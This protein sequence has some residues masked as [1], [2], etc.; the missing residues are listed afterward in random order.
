M[1]SAP[2]VASEPSPLVKRKLALWWVG[3]SPQPSPS[4]GAQEPPGRDVPI[5]NEAALRS[6]GGNDGAAGVGRD[7]PDVVVERGLGRIRGRQDDGLLAPAVEADQGRQILFRP[8]I[9]AAEDDRVVLRHGEMADRQLVEFGCEPP[10]LHKIAR[11]D[12]HVDKRGLHVGQVQL[13]AFAVGMGADTAIG[14]DGGAP[15]DNSAR[16]CGPTP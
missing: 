8:A 16:S 6:R 12:I 13:L 7:R 2:P 11:L 9:L 4:T 1:P 10:L 15:S 5:G 14:D 3:A